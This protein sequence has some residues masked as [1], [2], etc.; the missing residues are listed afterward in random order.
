MS[1][2]GYLQNLKYQG[3][4]RDAQA[5]EDRRRTQAMEDKQMALMDAE[6]ANLGKDADGTANEAVRKQAQKAA[7]LYLGKWNESLT[8]AEGMYSGA[9][10]RVDEAGK[11]ID[12]AYEN[13][14][15][16][17]KVSEDVAA[18]WNTFKSDF[19]GIQK[20]LVGGA[21]EAIGQRGELRRSFMDL[22]KGDEEGAAGRAMAD[23]AG[24][25]ERGR[26]AEAMRLSGMGIDPTSG[27]GRSAM[28]ESRNTEALNAAMAGNRARIDER[29]R[30]AGLTAQGLQLIDPSK[31]ISA[32]SQIQNLSS[33]LLA[34]RS[35]MALTKAGLQTDLAGA[36]GNLA[37][38]TANI[39]SGQARDI[40][41]QYG[42][43]GAGQQGIAYANTANTTAAGGGDNTVGGYASSIGVSGFE[44]QRQPLT[45]KLRTHLDSAKKTQSMRT[46][47]Y[48]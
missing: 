7:N 32:A 22:T 33:N 30:V 29:N 19:S 15:D 13:L 47:F 23:V 35:G 37:T 24:V 25:S 28:V 18:E 9:L 31:D 38:T 1:T 27:R 21:E 11:L 44:G 36:K 16:I 43:F 10:A 5:A 34:Q 6:I 17:D 3:Q 39:A 48:G 8:A 20:S 45:D 46:Q 2:F 40:A 42:E 26:Q 41:G 4:M 12:K 14:G